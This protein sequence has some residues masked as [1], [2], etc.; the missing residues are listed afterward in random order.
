MPA[1]LCSL[2]GLGLLTQVGVH[3][4]YFPLMF[5]AFL[6][7]GAGMGMASVPL[8]TIAMANVPPRD[9]GLA[10]GIVNVSMQVSGA[11]GV[12]ILGTIAT[13][14]T[15][16]LATLGRPL[17]SA[18]TGGYQLGFTVAAGCVLAALF[19]AL[20]V[21]RAPRQ[22]QAEHAGERSRQPGAEAA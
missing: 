17:T 10:S 8:L 14:R 9:A 21:L 6:L 11:L 3:G 18:L 19:F 5:F 15:K 2:V 13:D 7:M 22:T 4:D 1:I 12:A 16:T 20:V